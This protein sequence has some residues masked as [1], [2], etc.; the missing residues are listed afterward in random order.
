MSFAYFS[1]YNKES[2]LKDGR[3]M[4]TEYNIQGNIRYESSKC[5]CN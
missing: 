5:M 2:E 3:E 4:T 1:L